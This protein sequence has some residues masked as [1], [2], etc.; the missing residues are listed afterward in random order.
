MNKDTWKNYLLTIISK[1]L[2]CLAEID[3]KTFNLYKLESNYQNH[4]KI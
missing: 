4:P 1:P 2:K 3:F